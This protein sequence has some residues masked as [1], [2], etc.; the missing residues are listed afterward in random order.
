MA[1]IEFGPVALSPL[2]NV[3]RIHVVNFLDGPLNIVWQGRGGI[4]VEE[5]FKLHAYYCLKNRV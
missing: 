2:Y 3:D 1:V 4:W 5:G